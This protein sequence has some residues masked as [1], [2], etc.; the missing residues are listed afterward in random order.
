MSSPLP[1]VGHS[2]LDGDPDG[3]GHVSADEYRRLMSCYPTGVAIVT[4]ID[5]SG[6]PCGMTCSSLTSVSVEPPT[7]LVSLRSASRTL[8]A[9]RRGGRFAVNLLHSGGR[10]A[11]WVFSR[12]VPDRFSQTMWRPS[13]GF[14]APW[15]VD[16]AFAVAECLVT[17][18]IVVADHTIVLAEV[19]GVRQTE[20]TPLVYG[21]RRFSAWLS[22]VFTDAPVLG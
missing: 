8:D 9:V 16:D 6:A 13:P 11:A 1:R 12:R 7:L 19:V 22:D 20:A 5:H 17:R 15:L 21:M 2:G 4:A 10:R 14:G 3:A 18:E